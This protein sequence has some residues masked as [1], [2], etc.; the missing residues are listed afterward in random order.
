[1]TP[2]FRKAALTLHVLAS[3]GWIGSI[4]GFLVLAVV[5]WRTADIETMRACYLALAIVGWWAIVPLSLASFVTGVVQGLGTEWGVVRHWW[6]VAKLG[7]NVVASA[8]LLLHMQPVDWLAAAVRS[9]AI[10]P[11]LDGFRG[12]LVADA[13]AA[14]AVLVVATALSVWKPRG[15]TG[16]GAVEGSVARPIGTPR[17]V[18]VSGAALGLGFL[19]VVVLHLTGNGL[20]GMHR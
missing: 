11:E 7:I 20:G 14:V 3:V 9:S 4:L 19:V 17:W 15:R 13:G 16:Y 8:L 12:Q 2:P 18:V 1:M 6:V 10:P 5:G